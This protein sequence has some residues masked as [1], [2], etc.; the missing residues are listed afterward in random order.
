MDELITTGRVAAGARTVLAAF[1]A[2][3]TW[4]AISLTWPNSPTGR[5]GT[6]P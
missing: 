4:G 2:G 1:G 5:E 6:S 3:M